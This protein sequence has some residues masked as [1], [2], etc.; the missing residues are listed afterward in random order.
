M[1][2]PITFFFKKFLN[3]YY[4]YKYYHNPKW[5]KSLDNISNKINSLN[6]NQKNTKILF[7]PSFSIH[8]PSVALDRVLATKLECMGCEVVPMYCDAIQDTECNVY[9]G[10][11]MSD[12]NFKKACK[13]CE[14]SSQK[15]WK[16]H[17]NSLLKLSKF[18]D[19]KKRKKEIEKLLNH[20]NLERL[21]NY[22]DDGIN[23]GQ[24][25]KDILV[26]NQLVGSEKLVPKASSLMKSHI[27]NLI[28]LKES[29]S[30]VIKQLKPDRVISNDSYYGMWKVLEI[31][32][33]KNSIPFYSQY[34]I[35]SDRMVI[36]HN[37]SAVDFDFY[38]SWK[39]FC[40]KSLTQSEEK[41]INNWLKGKRGL[42]INTTR[43]DKN[44][45]KD[46]ALF[47]IDIG[48][49]TIVIA[50]NVIWDLAALNKQIIFSDMTNWINETIEWFDSK[51]EFQLIIK[52]HPGEVNKRIPK[53]NETVEHG[54]RSRYTKLPD[55]V[56]LL[57]PDTHLSSNK[58][59]K[60]FNVRGVAVHTTTVGFEYPIHGIPSIT[61]ARTPY[62]G[63]GFTIDPINK[64]EY[65]ES[66]NLLLSNPKKKVNKSKIKLAKKFI[67]FYQF[68]YFSKLNIFYGDPFVEFN[69]GFEE[70]I[71]N[72]YNEPLDYICKKIIEG[73]PVNS[74]FEWLPLSL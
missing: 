4:Y 34:P 61:T 51:T 62:R 23:Y 29:Y 56:H 15:M 55:N 2:D 3:K 8:Q 40:K 28:L 1:I 64:K 24:L 31:I 52:P 17:K 41:Q 35:T 6:I 74:Q 30:E 58:I 13:K 16:S 43:P 47:K 57:K 36:K 37:G 19:L 7:G 26:N 50:A 71:L 44:T 39:K 33:I 20:L 66:L 63:L 22:T 54:I 38:D 60:K 5:L 68:H 10:E 69:H 14:F 70:K 42:F 45:A 72:N 11:W 27:K 46:S 73:K 9:G 49:P 21:I 25:A 48:K 32:C 67:K 53:T 18:I 12:Q 65:F 59:M